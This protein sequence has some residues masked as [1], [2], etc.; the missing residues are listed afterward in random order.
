MSGARFIFRVVALWCFRR[1]ARVRCL[2]AGIPLFVSPISI[3]E[4]ESLNRGRHEVMRGI[5]NLRNC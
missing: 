5:V 2:G 4:Q 3:V 1:V